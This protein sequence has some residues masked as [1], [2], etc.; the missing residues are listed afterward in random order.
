MKD[1]WVDVGLLWLRVLVGLALMYHGWLKVQG[2]VDD[3]A[4]RSVE[5]LGF[6]VPILFAWLA[7]ASELLGGFFLFL[8]LWTRLSAFAVAIT[9]G[10]A[11]FGRN[12]GA[13]IIAPSA[14]RSME[15]PLAYLVMVVAI[16]LMGAG[17]ISVDAGRSGHGRSAGP[18][19]PKRKG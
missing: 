12:A 6:P 16:L 19:K 9:M 15:L 8:G 14:P 18:K 2:G 3:F 17:R 11:A 10:V 7:T 5:P 13:P 4:A 1:K